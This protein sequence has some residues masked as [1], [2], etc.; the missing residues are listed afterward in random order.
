MKKVC[1][2]GSIEGLT[3]L[4]NQFY[5]SE[6]WIINDKLEAYNT[7]LQKMAGKIELKRN[8]YTFYL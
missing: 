5:L 2:S 8:K 3:K 4:I 7:K 1:S 6:N